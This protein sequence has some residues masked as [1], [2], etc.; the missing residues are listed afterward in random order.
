MRVTGQTAYITE[1]MHTDN[2]ILV[3]PLTV[4]A[5]SDFLVG[6]KEDEYD[7]TAAR[8]L[9][10]DKRALLDSDF[11]TFLDPAVDQH[12]DFYVAME[13]DKHAAH[14]VAGTSFLDLNSMILKTECNN[15]YESMNE[16]DMQKL[17]TLM[18]D[19]YVPHIK[20]SLQ[21]EIHPG[22]GM[23]DFQA[24]MYVVHLSVRVA[25][26]MQLVFELNQ[27]K[28]FSA[29]AKTAYEVA[30]QDV[31]YHPSLKGKVHAMQ[32]AK[33]INYLRR[34]PQYSTAFNTY[35]GYK[36]LRQQLVRGGG[37]GTNRKSNDAERLHD[38][39]ANRLWSVLEENPAVY[40]DFTLASK[41]YTMEWHHL[42]Y[43]EVASTLYHKLADSGN[44]AANTMYSNISSETRHKNRAEFK[45][46]LDKVSSEGTTGVV[47]GSTSGAR[48]RPMMDIV[49]AINETRETVALGTAKRTNTGS[50]FTT[51]RLTP[52]TAVDTDS[53]LHGPHVGSK[54]PWN[55]AAGG[56]NTNSTGANTNSTGAIDT[57]NTGMT[58][59]RMLAACASLFSRNVFSGGSD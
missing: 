49:G 50:T 17:R 44:A 41:P 53:G 35:V 29:V 58:N 19:V 52:A 4:T 14:L 10:N 22:R 5:M 16:N 30:L 11:D 33:L 18:W 48:S 21:D 20:E 25:Q 15:V 55:S 54:R 45:V 6:E 56:A 12:S 13:R 31:L 9:E 26:A 24:Q 47:Q 28:S 23:N 36:L 38:E 37:A 32:Y 1:R 46:Q 51:A 7:D 27:K 42:Y 57:D 3:D 34:H 43:K 39:A 2:L 59:T 8:Q 40:S